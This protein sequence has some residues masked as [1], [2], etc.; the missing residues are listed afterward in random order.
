M[1]SLGSLRETIRENRPVVI[2]VLVITVVFFGL[3]L[4]VLTNL[5]PG[6]QDRGDA[7]IALAGARQQLADVQR[8]QNVDPASLQ[9]QIDTAQA[10]LTDSLRIFLTDAQASDIINAL[11]RY[12]SASGVLVTDLQ[13]QPTTDPAAAG[14]FTVTSVQLKAQ[15]SARQL[16]DFVSRIRETSARS[17]VILSINIAD[18]EP[19]DTLMMN[20]NLYT[21]PFATGEALSIGPLPTLG[22][23]LPTPSGPNAEAQLAQQL[24]GLWTAQDWPQVINVLEQIRAINPNFPDLNEKLYSAHINNG[25][26]LLAAGRTDDAKLEFFRALTVKPNGAEAIAAL[27]QLNPPT[28]TPR[29]TVYTVAPGDTLFSIARRFGTT[30]QAIQVANG[31]ADTSIRVGQQLIIPL[32]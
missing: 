5:L 28:S 11:Y 19:V 22:P 23:S 29:T 31:L 32:P 17:F 9:A 2:A 21:S 16:A 10:Q 30:A 4:F 8:S 20:M 3:V 7:A 27:N 24:D 15:G 6:M 26:R 1:N 12:A 18:G 13:S 14:A 25:Y